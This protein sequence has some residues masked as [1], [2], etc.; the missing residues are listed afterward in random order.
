M[1][2]LE[3]RLIT[4][5]E[6]QTGEKSDH[7]RAILASSRAAFWKF[8]ACLPLL[9]HRQHVPKTLWNLARIAAMQSEDCG[10]CLQTTVIYAL[11]DGVEGELIKAALGR[12]TS[13]VLTAEEEAA[14]AL[15]RTVAGGAPMPDEARRC[16]L[17]VLGDKGLAELSLA[18]AT[19]R[20]FPAIKRGLGMAEACH[21][22]T[23][24]V[25]AA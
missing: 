22:V 17:A 18:A 9:T 7:I 11:R 16:L 2:W 12:P 15:G 19:V 10:P 1:P 13:R 14:L 23:I 25:D 24:H 4:R 20:I 5:A 6:V 21:L 8:A 3:N